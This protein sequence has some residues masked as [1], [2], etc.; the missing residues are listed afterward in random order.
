MKREGIP[1]RRKEG[2][3]VSYQTNDPSIQGSCTL[4]CDRPQ[5]KLIQTVMSL[6]V[7]LVRHKTITALKYQSKGL[8]PPTFGSGGQTIPWS[9][10][11]F[12]KILVAVHL[13]FGNTF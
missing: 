10:H 1:L 12:I 13:E 2:Q 3:K 7:L 8:E 4:V 6:I 11:L 5:K 9:K